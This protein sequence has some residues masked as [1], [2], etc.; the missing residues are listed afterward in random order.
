MAIELFECNSNVIVNCRDSLLSCKVRHIAG[1][2]AVSAVTRVENE[3]TGNPLQL[4]ILKL[5]SSTACVKTA[6][7]N[8]MLFQLSLP[9]ARKERANQ[10]ASQPHKQINEGWLQY[11]NICGRNGLI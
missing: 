2:Y 8:T 4:S 5:D 10:K 7:N 1:Q 11:T 3:P 9:C 6:W